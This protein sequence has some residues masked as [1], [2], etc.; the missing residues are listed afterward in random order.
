MIMN[1]VIT[2]TN[3]GGYSRDLVNIIGSIE[4]SMF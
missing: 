3:R 4:M 2:S 1:I